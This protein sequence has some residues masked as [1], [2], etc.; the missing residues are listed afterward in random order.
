MSKLSLPDRP[1]SIAKGALPS[2]WGIIIAGLFIGALG[3]FML[4]WQLPPLLHDW[5]ISRNPVVVY[6][7]DIQNGRCTTRKG[8]FTDCEAHLS[9]AVD[10]TQYETD[11]AAMFVSFG[12]GDYMVDLVRSG[13]DPSLATISIG[14]EKMWNRIAVL[15]GFSVLL[16]G[17][18]LFALISGLSALRDRRIL[19]QAGRLIAVPV[20]LA[21]IEDLKKGVKLSFTDP[22][23]D[24]P[25]KKYEGTFIKDEP[26]FQESASGVTT[27]IAVRH[28]GGGRPVLLDAGLQ[29]LNLT[30][31][32]RRTALASLNG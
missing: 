16:L 32:E 10:G 20:P 27:G 8:I 12:S 7:G 15:T 22:T 26:L 9:Y 19:S 25:N 11:A 2:G 3:V 1:L 17:M 14:I 23:G 31:E 30:E 18:A 5:K 4:V 13:D 6:D 21:G 28:E 29:R 24:R